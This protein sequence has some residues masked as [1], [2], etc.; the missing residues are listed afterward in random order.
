M[1]LNVNKISDSRQLAHTAG[2][3]KNEKKTHLAS[4]DEDSKISKK[5]IRAEYNFW[6]YVCTLF[7]GVFDNVICEYKSGE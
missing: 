7:S 5:E 1:H 2:K 4:G 6:W 3:L